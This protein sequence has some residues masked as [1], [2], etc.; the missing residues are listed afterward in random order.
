MAISDFTL[1]FSL[2]LYL[3]EIFHNNEVFKH[4]LVSNSTAL[5][6]GQCHHHLLPGRHARQLPDDIPS[7]QRCPL[8]STLLM[9]AAVI[10]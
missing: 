9:A 10:I 1:P 4:S 2:I 6:P 8:Q 7:I 5:P 3:F